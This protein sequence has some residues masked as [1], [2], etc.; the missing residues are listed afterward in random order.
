MENVYFLQVG[1][2]KRD[3]LLQKIL[4]LSQIIQTNFT[5]VTKKL[6]FTRYF[7]CLIS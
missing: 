2:T 3:N 6:D 5:T 1:L 4:F 7:I